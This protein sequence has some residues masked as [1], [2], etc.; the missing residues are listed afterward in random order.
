MNS[1]DEARLWAEAHPQ[2]EP[3]ETLP[4]VVVQSYRFA[5]GTTFH[6]IGEPDDDFRPEQPSPRLAPAAPAVTEMRH[7][8]LVERSEERDSA[9]NPMTTRIKL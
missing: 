6:R 5:D 7:G 9:G 8:A 2:P 3:V 1:H 4:P